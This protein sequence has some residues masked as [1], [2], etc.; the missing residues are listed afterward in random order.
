MDDSD[1]EMIDLTTTGAAAD[2]KQLETTAIVDSDIDTESDFESVTSDTDL[3]IQTNTNLQGEPTKLHWKKLQSIL[4]SLNPLPLFIMIKNRFSDCF[5]TLV[6]CFTCIASCELCSKL[7]AGGW[8]CTPQGL[9]SGAVTR[10]KQLGQTARLLADRRIFLSVSLYGLTSFI[11]ILQNE[12]LPLLLVTSHVHGGYNMDD[13]EIGIIL[14]VSAVTQLL[15]QLFLFPRITSCIGYRR[16]FQLGA[17]FFAVVVFLPPL[18]NRITGPISV[19][20]TSS[21]AGSGGYEGLFGSGSETDFCGNDVSN[22]SA[23]VNEN[24][25][26]RVPFEVWLVLCLVTS[27][28]IIA[29]IMNL[30]SLMVLIG[31]SALP[32]NRASVNGIAQASAALGRFL[33]PII[34]APL[35]AWSESNGKGWPLNYHFVFD[36]LALVTVAVVIVSCFLPK[37]IEKKIDTLESA[38][39]GL[40]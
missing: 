14:M 15:W 11:F 22:G 18:A 26:T 4:S 23:S 16:S 21:G 32:A 30:T 20:L 38:G 17:I 3:L 37:T 2:S 28:M 35:F 10:L 13:T 31:N 19:S 5:Q 6:I 29:R 8:R 24:S 33:G 27:L 9:R 25:V 39:S 12:L 7:K 1:T 34:G 36:L 40:S